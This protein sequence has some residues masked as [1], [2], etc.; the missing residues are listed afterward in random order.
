[1]SK[2]T[3]AA[4]GRHVLTA[5][6]SE[7]GRRRARERRAQASEVRRRQASK[8]REFLR[9]DARL[10]AAYMDIVESG[11]SSQEIEAARAAWKDHARGLS[12]VMPASRRRAGS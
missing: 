9:E 11:G 2:Q 7:L 3:R 6:E 4:G 10:Y 5:V 8:R 12:E 1:M